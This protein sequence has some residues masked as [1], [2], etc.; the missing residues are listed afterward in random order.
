MSID[1]RALANRIT[2]NVNEN[3]SI[4]WVKSTGYTTNAAGKRTPT[5]TT[6]VIQANIQ[7]LDSQGLAHTDSLNI[8]GTLRQVYMYGNVQDLVRVDQQGGDILQFPEIPGGTI[9]NWL[10]VKVLETWPTWCKVIVN[11]QVN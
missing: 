3:Q 10:V 6:T 5:N 7:A 4:S 2:Q 11:L 1:V 8:Q 9:R